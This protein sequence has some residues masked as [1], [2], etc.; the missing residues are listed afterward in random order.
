[1][2]DRFFSKVDIADCWTW[3]AARTPAGY[4]SFWVGPG[5]TKVM[6]H[7][8]AWEHLRGPIP[9]GQVIDHLC[10][11]KACVNPDH[12]DPVPQQVNL[13]RGVGNGSQTHC[14]QGHPYDEVNTYR[15]ANGIRQCRACHAAQ[16]R[17]RKRRRRLQPT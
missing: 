6:A 10:R 7:R 17:E 14:P 3:T 9:E 13:A 12:L 8:W 2:A 16:E 4:G 11:N 15:R 1:M 5:N